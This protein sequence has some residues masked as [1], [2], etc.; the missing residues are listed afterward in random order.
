MHNLAFSHIIGLANP[1]KIASVRI[2]KFV[3][4]HP[5]INVTK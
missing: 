2:L 1:N 5:L 4:G 3:L